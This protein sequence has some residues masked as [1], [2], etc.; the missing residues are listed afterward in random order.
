LLNGSGQGGKYLCAIA[1]TVGV[2]HRV[3]DRQSN[4]PAV[5]LPASN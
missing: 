4:G 5:L 1:D 3:E 2:P